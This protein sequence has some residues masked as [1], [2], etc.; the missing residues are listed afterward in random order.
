MGRE[1]CTCSRYFLKRQRRLWTNASLY[2]VSRTA[3]MCAV[4]AFPSIQ[5]VSVSMDRGM[6]SHDAPHKEQGSACDRATFKHRTEDHYVRE[7]WCERSQ[8]ALEVLLDKPAHGCRTTL[9]Y[10]CTQVQHSTEWWGRHLMT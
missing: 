3:Q 2:M 6:A 1:R 10:H 5:L 7:A 4:P 9:H 8:G